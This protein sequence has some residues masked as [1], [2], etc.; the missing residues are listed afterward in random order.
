M[1]STYGYV[2]VSST[3]QN[4]DRQIT[5]MRAF[6]IPDRC[7]F[8]DKKSGSDF[9]RPAYRKL[10]RKLKKDD[11]LVVKSI[12]R[13][14]R[15]YI[16]ITAEWQLIT[17]QMECDILVLDM[18]LLDTRIR[19]DNL[20]GRFISDIVLQILS[21]VAE[22]EREN[23]KRRQA[24]G[25]RSAQKRGVRFGRPAVVLAPCFDEICLLYLIGRLPL[26]RALRLLRLKQSTFYKYYQGFRQR[27]FSGLRE[28]ET[29]FETWKTQTDLKRLERD[30]QGKIH[31]IFRS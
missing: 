12:D 22:N 6:G 27:F 23:I 3:D 17:K 30:L 19:A 25:I 28:R 7:I 29:D 26:K 31:E 13:L 24:E 16:A 21:F 10:I 9:E 2:R 4:I 5:E 11:L 8:V 1:T 18:P 14:G 15:N 20:M